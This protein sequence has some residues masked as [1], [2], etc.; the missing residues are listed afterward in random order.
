MNSRFP[1]SKT[2]NSGVGAGAAAADDDRECNDEGKEDKASNGNANY[3]TNC[4]IASNG[5][6]LAGGT[7]GCSAESTPVG[8]Y[9]IVAAVAA[10][11][12]I[13]GN[14]SCSW[15]SYSTNASYCSLFIAGE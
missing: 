8:D 11:G 1:C 13:T 2:C 5:S 15:S 14:R 3:L 7:V 10:A 12:Q 9:T 6:I 4:E